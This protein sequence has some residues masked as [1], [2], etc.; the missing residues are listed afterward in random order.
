MPLDQYL[1]AM[2]DSGRAHNTDEARLQALGSAST[3]IQYAGTGATQY[4]PGRGPTP[5]TP[6]PTSAPTSA[7]TPAPTDPASLATRQWQAPT[8]AA[9]DT[10]PSVLPSNM[11]QAV[12]APTNG[13]DPNGPSVGGG[14]AASSGG[15]AAQGGGTAPISTTG[16]NAGVGLTPT[17]PSN[18]LTAQT[19]T[20]NNNI[21]RVKL[22][23]QSLQSTIDN[24]LNPEFQA[25][26]RATNELSFGRGRGVS[27]MNRTAQGNVESDYER[28]K[29]NL[30][31]QLITPAISGSIDDL[32]RNVGISQQQQGFQADQQKTAFQQAA[33]AQGLS[34]SETSQA[35]QQALQMF[36]AGQISDPAQFLEYLSGQYARP[37]NATA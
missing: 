4:A 5:S 35:F 34:D 6:T 33:Q 12:I 27:G 20:P 17:D 15:A 11:A 16:P 26:E 30:A 2:V 9:P 32:Y 19:I 22:A 10:N 3:G 24:M 28:T 1:Q 23:Q 25:D 31:N 14:P 29:A 36:Y 13:S 8:G 21:D 37:I 18:P 7:P